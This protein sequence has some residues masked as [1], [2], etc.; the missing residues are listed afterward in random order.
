MIDGFRLALFFKESCLVRAMGETGQGTG[1][2]FLKLNPFELGFSKVG[3]K[4]V[5]VND[6][7]T[8]ECCD[9]YAPYESL[10]S[11]YTG[12][13]MKLFNNVQYGDPYVEIK[14][15]PAKLMQGHNVYGSDDIQQCAFEMLGLLFQSMPDLVPFLNLNC[16]QVKHIDITYSSRVNHQSSLPKIID[17]L[18]R[19][20]HNQTKPTA[21]K[22][23]KTTAYWGGEHSRLQQLKCYAK[24][25][26]LLVQLQDFK[27]QAKKGC[28]RSQMIVDTVYTD[29]LLDFSKTLLRWEARLKARKFER[30]GI[31]TDLINLIKYQQQN[32][33]CLREL[34]QMSFNPIF[35][36]IEGE[37]MPYANDFEIY[38]LL[39]QKLVYTTKRG[40]KS[41][42]R[43]NNAMNFYHLIRDIGMI[44]VKKR[45]ASRTFYDH[46]KLLTDAGIS[47][48]WLQNLHV[49]RKGQ[50]IPLVR[51]CEVNFNAQ[52]PQDYIPPVSKYSDLLKVA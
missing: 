3:A 46:L 32:P 27:K 22:K 4:Q 45:Y 7:G 40:K 1:Q 48:A 35:Q 2:A 16:I 25:D 11:N 17:Y 33:N 37:S 14:G 39:K 18:S 31:P 26:E 44:E 20:S 24:H 29:E 41:Y 36:T 10:A 6:D 21:D 51:F 30:L 13:A 15:S 52:A 9:L 19:I 38:E 42:T 47:K 49:E 5:H 12:M 34:W 8:F 28:K 50:V 23:Y 43:A